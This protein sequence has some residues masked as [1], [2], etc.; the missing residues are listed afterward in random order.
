[1]KIIDLT[2]ELSKDFP[3]LTDHH[4]SDHGTYV[5]APALLLEKGKTIDKFGPEIFVRDAVLLDLTHKK[6]RQ[7]IDDEDL[8]AAEERAGLAVRESE[9]VVIHTGWDRFL[10]SKDYLLNHPYLS[11]NGAQYLEFKNV[12]GVGVDS[13]NLENPDSKNLPIHEI[14]LRKEIL[15][16]ENLC[17]LNRI[18]E[19]RFRLIALPLRVNASSSPVRAI[20]VID[21]RV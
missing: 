19:P 11:E 14:L 7:P 5:D 9:F 18:E 1:M 8:E 6:P 15:I 4:A 2:N 3:V 12:S 16:L 17:N 10:E 13:P 20:A 21:D